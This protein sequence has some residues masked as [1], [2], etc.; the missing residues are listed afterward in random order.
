MGYDNTGSIEVTMNGL[1]KTGEK[2]GRSTIIIEEED[3]SKSFEDKTI[4]INVLIANIF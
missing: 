4:V 3:P 2:R 1:I